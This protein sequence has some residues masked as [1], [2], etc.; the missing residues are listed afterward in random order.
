MSSE[1]EVGKWKL[2]CEVLGVDT[3]GLAATK[4]QYKRA[5]A[6]IH[7]N[8]FD[9]LQHVRTGAVGQVRRFANVKELAR[10]SK[11]RGRIFPREQAKGGAL[12]FLLRVLFG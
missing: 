9:L 12:R 4:C 11:R 8:I 1:G 5:L 6:G 10:Y 7:V 2:L 3:E